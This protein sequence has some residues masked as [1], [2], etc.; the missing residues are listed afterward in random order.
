MGRWM[1]VCHAPCALS[2]DGVSTIPY[3]Y[4][5]PDVILY[6]FSE[7]LTILFWTNVLNHFSW[8]ALDGNHFYVPFYF[9]ISEASTAVLCLLANFDD[10][11][12]VK[13]LADAY[14]LGKVI[15]GGL[16]AVTF[17][18]CR[19]FCWSTVSF[20]YCRDA[21]HALQNKEDPRVQVRSAWLKFTFVSLGLLSILQIVWLGEIVKIGKEEL[22]NMGFLWGT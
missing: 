10:E 6:P 9:G 18:I 14:P 13:G 3:R 7:F 22:V 11:F 20:Y 19:V 8:G 4:W 15:L 16:F 12:G 21:W 1:G 17:V 2:V 5:A